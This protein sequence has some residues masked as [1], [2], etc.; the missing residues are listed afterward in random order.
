MPDVAVKT[1]SNDYLVDE[2]GCVT[3]EAASSDV[4]TNTVVDTPSQPVASSLVDTASYEYDIANDTYVAR[5]GNRIVIDDNSGT[6]TDCYVV[7]DKPFTVDM[8]AVSKA[9]KTDVDNASKS[10]FISRVRS[11]ASLI[12]LLLIVM[13]AYLLLHALTQAA[14]M[15]AIACLAIASILVIGWSYV[16]ERKY[17]CLGTRIAESLTFDDPST[18]AV[19]GDLVERGRF[20]KSGTPK[21]IVIDRVRVSC[22]DS[23]VSRMLCDDWFQHAGGYDVVSRKTI[24]D[25]INEMKEA[26]K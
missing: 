16:A 6:I 7:T 1:K 12:T 9:Y 2:Y 26:K 22:Y 4:L 17:S 3:S 19:S 21:V 8:M 25:V 24:A 15:F 23:V 11:T 10:E 20:V 18:K 14:V 5:I 13:F